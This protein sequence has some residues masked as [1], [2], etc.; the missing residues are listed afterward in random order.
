MGEGWSLISIVS[1]A[2]DR[3]SIM[4]LIMAPCIALSVVWCLVRVLS[5]EC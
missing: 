1:G 5:G 4:A 3:P 2:G